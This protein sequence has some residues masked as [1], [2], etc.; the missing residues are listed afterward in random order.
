MSIRNSL[1]TTYYKSSYFFYKRGFG[2]IPMVI[3]LATKFRSY[4]TPNF[5]EINGHKLFLDKIDAQNLWLDKNF[6][7]SEIKSFKKLIKKGDTV[8]DIGTY[9]GLHTLTF[10]KLVG[11][12]GKVISFEP[13][14]SNFELLK[15]NVEINGYTNVI[16]VN[17]AVSN[18]NGNEKLYLS[19]LNPGDTRLGD[20][21]KEFDKS[22]KV[23]TIRIDD[24]LDDDVDFIKMDIQG[25]EP[26]AIDGMTSLLQKKSIKI[27]IEFW[28]FG[29]Q[30]NKVNVREFLERLDSF[31]FNFYDFGMDKE[32]TIEQLLTEYAHTKKWTNLLCQKIG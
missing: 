2:K 32:C 26:F 12:Q 22:I 29:I 28:P 8:L 6:E 14:P 7:K 18:R 11:N 21:G 13:V 15:K 31:G 5:I 1:L 19:N 27:L 20:F 23:K 17:K 4:V 10:A 24:Y 16:L 25:A 3:S 30:Q 9:I